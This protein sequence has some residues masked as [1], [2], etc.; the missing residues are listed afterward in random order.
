[1]ESPQQAN[2]Q[3]MS[4]MSQTANNTPT[5]SN[6]RRAYSEVTNAAVQRQ[7]TTTSTTETH[8]FPRREQAIVIN[9]HENLKLVDYVTCIGNLIGPKEVLFASRISNSRIC[10]FLT[11]TK[12]VDFIIR[13]H[14]KIIINEY[15]LSVRRLITPAKRI[16]ISNVCP[17]I[18]H[19]VIEQV[20]LSMGFKPV[21]P[22]SFLRAGLQ[23]SDY[24]HVLSFRRHIY[25]QPNDNISLSSSTVIKYLETNYR[26]FLNYDEMTCYT[27]KQPGHVASNCHHISQT[28]DTMTTDLQVT[29]NILSNLETAQDTPMLTSESQIHAP[30]PSYSTENE[31]ALIDLSNTVNETNKRVAVSPI[32]SITECSS[33]TT[34]SQTSK[35]Q[36]EIIN[37]L[38][39]PVSEITAHKKQSKKMK[40]SDS[41][42]SITPINELLSPVKQLIEA[43]KS[44]FILDHDQLIHLFENVQGNPDPLS[45]SR[46]YTNDTNALINMLI[47]LKPHF[48]HRSIKNR[49]TRLVK[50]LQQQLLQE[51]EPSSDSEQDDNETQ[52]SQ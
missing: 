36:E 50:R 4:Q 11:D 26:I 7:P 9:V 20:I 10:I 33:I 34:T 27:C 49:C 52:T 44:N 16:I 14:S 28:Q 3:Q 1:M 6:N 29:H 17:S 35:A 41:C 37:L 13:N 21:S 22:V 48:T 47:I 46:Q 43:D 19:N 30:T 45:I 15:E 24:T 40:R 2:P 38:S 39:K 42:E 51:K 32:S 8:S 25:V 23:S 31:S 12:H 5:T 18:P